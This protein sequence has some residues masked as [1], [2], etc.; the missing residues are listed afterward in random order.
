MPPLPSEEDRVTLTRLEEGMWQQA[1]R[2]DARFQ[3]ASLAKGFSEFGRSGRVNTR[4]EAL[5]TPSQP[6]HARLPLP[7]LPICLLDDHTAQLTY[8]SVFTQDG[9]VAYARHSANWSRT[10]SGWVLRFHQGT[11]D[12]L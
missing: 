11:P 2:F 9:L 8:S 3:Q 1:T 4:H 5:A 6:I 12:T 10:P 7:N